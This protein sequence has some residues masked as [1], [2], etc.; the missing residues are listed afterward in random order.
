[1]RC[2]ALASFSPGRYAAIDIGTVTCRLLIA[3]VDNQGLHELAHGYGITNLGEGVDAS[4]FLSD[5]AMERVARQ[6]SQFLDVVASHRNQENPHIEI[7]AMATSAS[8]DAKNGA[9]FL[10]M[11]EK[12]GIVP[13]I[14]S[15][16]KEAA[17]SFLGVSH[18]FSTSKLL[19]VD[20]GGGST[21]ISAG[22]YGQDLVLSRS[23]DV[24]CRRL[25]E[26][27]FTSDPPCEAELTKARLWI[28]ENLQAYFS[29]LANTSFEAD[30]MVA[31]AGT[32]TS[33]VSVYEKMASYDRAKVHG[34]VVDKAM[35][36]AVFNQLYSLT[37]E[38][39]KKVIGLDPGR[40]HVIV[41]GLLILEEVMALSGCSSFTVS[42]ADVLQGIILD[43]SQNRRC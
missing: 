18:E 24:G 10:R 14:I 9:E 12:L 1:M 26:R 13:S 29:D 21:E 38:E 37:L 8:R 25:T 43:A 19:V 4:G 41:A 33:I 6:I 42:E 20:V 22:A 30:Q 5:A 34:S 16:F 27:F 11:L 7:V 40:A 35:F 17:L 2:S 3:D 28:R 36:E 23:M 31:V 15:G 39:R 32:A